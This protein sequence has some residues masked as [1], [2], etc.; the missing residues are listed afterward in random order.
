MTE[1]LPILKE[2]SLQIA[3]DSFEGTGDIADPGN[4]EIL[5]EHQC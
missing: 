3:W 2:S 4:R 1:P 5:L